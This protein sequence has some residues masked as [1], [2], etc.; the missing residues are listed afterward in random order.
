MP[1]LSTEKNQG[2]RSLAGE[3][4]V[5]VK[6]SYETNAGES[7]H[8]ASKRKYEEMTHAHNTYAELFHML[9]TQGQ[10]E[11]AEIFRQIRG[12]HSPDDVLRSIKT[13][14]PTSGISEAKK[15]AREFFLV[16]LAHSTGSLQDITR[17]AMLIMHPSTQER[18]PKPK[19]FKALRNRI[20]RVQQ[21]EKLLLHAGSGGGGTPSP[22]AIGSILNPPD[23]NGRLEKV[24]SE[25]VE[26]QG[27]KF[28]D[29]QPPH[30]VSA[31]PWTT[32]TTNDEAL[33]S[34]HEVAFSGEGRDRITR[35]LHFH[36]EA[37]R[38]WA[39]EEYRPSLTN[40]QALCILSLESNY[41]AKDRL[42]LTLIPIAVQ[43]NN[44]LPV[45]ENERKAV[46]HGVSKRVFARVRLSAHW[47]AKCTHII[48]RLA[49]MSPTTVTAKVSGL[50]KI[51]EV[52]DDRSELWMSYPF[53]ADLV[54]YRPTL[55]LIERCRLAELFQEMHDLIFTQRT[56]TIQEFAQEAN[57]LSA[58]VQQWH[59][60]L[61]FELH[62]EWP[63]S[64]CVWEL[65]A[66]YLTSLMILW[67][68]A[69]TKFEHRDTTSG[70]THP[71][72]EDSDPDE[73]IFRTQMSQ[74]QLSNAITLA[75][76]AAQ[77]LR[78]FRERYGLKVTPAWLLQLQAVT[79]G[80]LLQDPELA[81]P[82]VV[83]SPEANASER[84]IRNSHAAF[85]EVFRCLLGT[86]VEVMIARGI[87]RMMYHTA[88]DRKIALSRSTRSML[89][90]M[91]N[92]A[93]RP[94][95]LSLVSSAFPNYAASQ[96]QEGGERLSELLSKW[97]TLEI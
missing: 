70:Q 84:D 74:E 39:L 21:V 87:A 93:W 19:D 65:H 10:R 67:T 22:L 9:R 4:N 89:Q 25:P 54:A 3:L 55:Y 76:R 17:L 8:Q 61:P 20:V 79:A 13:G 57:Q 16:S 51:R 26:S 42:G 63:M 92:T 43:L 34:E 78:D 59:Q 83:S 90:L 66:S 27:E 14:D 75:H 23:S 73:H 46:D 96:G 64:I 95:D 58:K 12:G 38:L 88:L 52:Y 32:I 81:D 97:E 2:I 37:L 15:S 33:H 94:S 35:G 62:Y 68:A 56:M 85:D 1:T 30:Q 77:I 71:F 11:A 60:R 45:S 80:V 40:I 6:C 29:D 44:Q 5:A 18:L 86:G 69:K 7:R 49:F 47:T 72:G 50:P 91:S 82:T 41:R 48:M 28:E 31:R 36:D 53:T 24:R